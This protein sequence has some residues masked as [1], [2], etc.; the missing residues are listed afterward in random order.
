MLW[1]AM[2][3]GQ[4]KR[5]AKKDSVRQ[6]RYN[7]SPTQKRRRAIRNEARRKAM[8]AG[9][10]RKHDGKDIDHLD[11]RSL[12]YS[13]TRVVSRKT[14]RAKNSPLWKKRGKKKHAV[15]SGRK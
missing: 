13:S 7:S 4:F 2:K 8:K 5:T 9:R 12:S 15:R 10:V 3:R 6:R 1:F 11:R 14:N